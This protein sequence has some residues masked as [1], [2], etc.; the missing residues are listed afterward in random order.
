[1][2]GAILASQR[3]PYGFAYDWPTDSV[4]TFSMMDLIAH[5]ESAPIRLKG[6]II[7]GGHSPQTAEALQ[8]MKWE[9]AV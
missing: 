7:D 5:I 1:V 3:L 4:R 6:I 9:G 8:K 2:K